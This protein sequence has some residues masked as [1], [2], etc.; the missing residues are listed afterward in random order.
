V[1]VETH[2]TRLV[3][4]GFA[5]FWVSILAH[6]GGHFG[7]AAVAYSTVHLAKVPDHAALWVVSAGPAV[8]WA[9]LLGCGLAVTVRR[10]ARVLQLLIALG[11]GAASRIAFVG[12]G[13]LLGTAVNDERTVSGILGV[14]ARLVWMTEA[15]AAA[16]IMSW[17]T[18]QLPSGTRLR[19][20]VWILIGT[21][22]GWG[23]A[24]TFGRWIGL[25][26]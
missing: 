1:P 3:G 22:V 13:T 25:R 20:G 15:V 11:M 17:M 8:T 19:T 16:L 7:V 23:S 18:R 2:P 5:M 12:P 14:S 26:I 9:I 4:I 6:E 24:L 10:R 21:S